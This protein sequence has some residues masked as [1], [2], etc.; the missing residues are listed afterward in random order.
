MTRDEIV[1]HPCRVL[2]PEQRERYFEQGF[3][4]LESLLGVV[5][6]SS[7]DARPYTA[8]SYRSSHHL[9]VVRGEPARYAHHE[10]VRLPLPP[11]WSG[12]YTSIFADQ[13]R[14]AR[15]DR[16][17]AVAQLRTRIPAGS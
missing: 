16:A 7:S 9:A 17:A 6:Y 13:Q 12:G 3:V 10:A 2:T 4:A 5:G 8:F 1:S 14:E 15:A 11:D